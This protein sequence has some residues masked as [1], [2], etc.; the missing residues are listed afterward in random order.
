MQYKTIYVKT[1]GTCNLN[2]SHCFTN[3][4]NG[5]KTQFDPKQTVKWIEDY[6]AEHDELTQYHLELH[7]GE[8]FLVPLEK[9]KEVT[10]PFW[11]MPNVSIAAN[12]NLVFKLHDEIVYFILE[13]FKGVIGTSWDNWIRFGNEAQLKL[14][15][16]NLA[17]LHAA[18]AYISLKVSVSKQLVDS[19]PDWFL[20]QMDELPVDTISLERIT[21]GGN[22]VIDNGVFPNNEDQ[23]LWYLELYKRYFARKPAY[24][25]ST[26]DTLKEKI[27]TNQVKVDTNCRNCEQNL[28]TIN[29]NGTLGGCPNVAT[30]KNHATIQE[31]AKVFLTSEGRINDITKELNFPEGCLRCDVFDICGGDCHRLPWKDGRCGGLK[32][33]LRY[34]SGRD[35]SSNLIIKV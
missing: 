26:L 33:T 21:V 24:K 13:R 27:Q 2:C 31:S 11:Q 35:T 14:W 1:T 32:K 4:K 9:L 15:K 20:D 8:P 29:S 23:D 5:D 6:M 30:E 22:A 19:S 34:I 16:S 10:D 25:I 28:V 17:K 7:G 12:S 18:G 3:G